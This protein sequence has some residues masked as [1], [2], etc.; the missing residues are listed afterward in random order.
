MLLNEKGFPFIV[1]EAK[2]KDKHPLIGKEQARKYAESQKCRFVI[3]SNG[4]LHYFW[5]LQRGNPEI[6]PAFPNPSSV[7]DYQKTAPDRDRLIKEII[8]DDYVVLTQ[9]PNYQT[10]AAWK[11]ES[12]RENFKKINHLRFLRLYQLQALY[13]I[14]KAVRERLKR[15]TG[16]VVSLRQSS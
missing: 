6:I 3:L 10:E 12:E 1:L 16:S 7:M 5:D 8:N 15:V 11:K 2:A 4:D 13:A 9:L 14:Q